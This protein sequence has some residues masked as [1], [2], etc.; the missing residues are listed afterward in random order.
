MED[1][2]PVRGASLCY[3]FMPAASERFGGDGMNRYAAGTTRWFVCLLLACSGCAHW[4]GGASTPDLSRAGGSRLE[5]AQMSERLGREDLAERFYRDV[6]EQQPDSQLAHHRLAALAARAGRFREADEHFRLARRSGPPNADLLTDI[7]YAQYERRQ[8]RAA[9]QT[10]RQALEIDPNHAKSRSLLAL[11]LSEQGRFREGLVEFRQAVRGIEDRGGAAET[12]GT[13]VATGVA[14][15]PRAST[16]RTQSQLLAAG[17]RGV[18]AEVQEQEIKERGSPE[19]FHDEPRVVREITREIA[20]P[21]LA[22]VRRQPPATTAHG[23]EPRPESQRQIGERRPPDATARATQPRPG[24]APVAARAP[25]PSAAQSRGG[26]PWP[27]VHA[28]APVRLPP[29]PELVAQRPAGGRPSSEHSVIVRIDAPQPAHLPPL[30]ADDTPPLPESGPTRRVKSADPPPPSRVSIKGPKEAKPGSDPAAAARTTATEKPSARAKATAAQTP[31][32]AKPASDQKIAKHAAHD[33]PALVAPS[34]SDR[35]ALTGKLP[36]SAEG[37]SK[38]TANRPEGKGSLPVDEARPAGVEPRVARAAG[39]SLSTLGKMV[40]EDKPSRPTGR[41]SAHPATLARDDAKIAPPSQAAQRATAPED[42]GVLRRSS[43]GARAAGDEPSHNASALQEASPRTPS[44]DR[45]RAS[46]EARLASFE[47][48]STPSVG[49][50]TSTTREDKK[51]QSAAPT[52]PESPAVKAAPRIPTTPAMSLPVGLEFS[53]P[54]ATGQSKPPS[55][56]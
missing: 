26:A 40:T 21:S 52:A 14:P 46:H 7:A 47:E 6:L 32:A 31:S 49:E 55:T 38:P 8:A 5:M 3:R 35:S 17:V 27:L 30:T 2:A 43:R 41:S 10:L 9:E 25:A 51:P 50:A 29:P 11:V 53:L 13:L 20:P 19:E 48:R 28:T 18:P 1:V 33:A 24:T 22:A 4:P 34:K 12:Y 15:S 42:R 39:P 44:D 45:P 36:R 37:S 23:D 54:K 56:K 16:E